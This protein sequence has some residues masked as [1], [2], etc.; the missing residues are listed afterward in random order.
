MPS[1]VGRPPCDNMSKGCC[2]LFFGVGVYDILNSNEVCG[3][4]HVQVHVCSTLNETP[5]FSALNLVSC[6]GVLNS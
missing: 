4:G 3:M 2:V 5:K 6:L 1:H